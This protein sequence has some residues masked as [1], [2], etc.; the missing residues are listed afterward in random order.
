MNTSNIKKYAPKARNDFIAAIAKQAAKYGITDKSIEPVVEKGDLAVI[1]DSVFPSTVIKARTAL[2]K[3][4]EQLGFQQVVEQVAYSW[5]NRLC[6]IRYMELKGYLDHGRRVLS[7]A[8]GS[9][10]LPQILEDCLD[11]ELPGLNLEKVR[12][13]KL[14]GT[15]DEALYRELLLGQCHALHQAMPFLFESV[16][17][18]SELL[19][20][21]NLTKTDSLIRE[22]VEVIPEEDWQEV[23]VIGWLYQFY[24]S[25]KKDQVIGKV[26]KSEDIPAATQLFT[27]NWI[28]KYLVQNS[29]GRQ[30]LQTYPESPLKSQ[31]EYYIEPAEQTAEVQEQLKAITP[32]QIDPEAIKVLDPA[33]GSGH[34]LVEAYKVLKAI[35]EERGYRSR[36]IPQ[37]ILEKNL[38]GLDIDDRAAQLAGFALLMLAREDDRRIF[39]RELKLNVL[40]V[41]ESK[42]ID[43]DSN[44]RDAELP[45]DDTYK[46]AQ[47]VWH[48]FEQG[49]TFG[50]LIDIPASYESGLKALLDDLYG[51]ASQG[52]MLQKPAA[53][54]LLTIVNQALVLSQRYDAVVANP[55]YM[56]RSYY[57]K[58]LKK[59]VDNRFEIVKENIFSVFMER[60]FM[61]L[62]PAGVNAQINMH[63]WMFISRFEKYRD[64]LL[65]KHSLG[66]MLHLGP[67][68]FPEISGEVVQNTAFIYA[69]NFI[70]GYL[71][72]IYRLVD[73]DTDKKE[74]DFLEGR[75]K[76]TF[77][78]LNFLNI[79]GAPF[80]YW[81]SPSIYDAFNNF[82]TAGNHIET[83][84][85]L[86]TANNDLFLR[87]WYEVNDKSVANEHAN[88]EQKKWFPY[89]KGGG[90]RRWYGYLDL[91]VNWEN[92]GKDVRNNIDPITGRIRSHNYNGE[93][94][95]R[96]GFTWSGISSAGFSVRYVPQGYMF[97]AKGPMGFSSPENLLPFMA[98]FNC[99][100]S[101]FLMS[102]LAPTLDFKLGH[103]LKLPLQ[104][105][106]ED[107]VLAHNA[108]RCIDI[109]R[110]DWDSFE[111]SRGF[112]RPNILD[113]NPRVRE[114]VDNHL[115]KSRKIVDELADLERENNRILLE[116]YSLQHVINPDIN[117]NE[118]TLQCNLEYRYSGFKG[119]APKR[120]LFICDLIRELMSYSIGC[121]MGRY[122][123]DR[124]GLIYA[125]ESNTG[126]SGI[127]GEDT[128]KTFPADDDGI[129]P[130][131]DQ[132]WFSDDASNRFSDF[133][134][135][136]WQD[137]LRGRSKFCV[138][139]KTP[140]L[141]HHRSSAPSSRPSKKMAN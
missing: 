113:G 121:M 136:A 5:F 8:D 84:E 24:I 15:K 65:K 96:E 51:I 39:G 28:V 79:D 99:K 23:E 74:V 105:S 64:N 118:V 41:Q 117:I 137:D 27:P 2:A 31:M 20:P 126:F 47:D 63:A 119:D 72:T 97:D 52:G 111:I 61:L 87:S 78:C 125:Q 53:Q 80:V 40:A 103:V 88:K 129:I 68:A 66:S 107:G 56:G 83:R 82:H 101:T 33:C 128:Y 98:F 133:I 109:S 140:N 67:N 95:Y 38:Y 120:D 18:E 127:V 37:L 69:N 93:Y 16:D 70:D 132:E 60:A 135:V 86:A 36:D 71:S 22:L 10:G 7:S 45:E 138:K 114:S 48:R 115:I 13:L 54:E 102:M 59:F 100:I 6:A 77:D 26:V 94:A 134:G 108:K 25:E 34:I 89:N 1:G 85:G 123:L 43:L 29:V 106:N 58:D 112:S 3:K 35:Y 116:R 91:L 122:S 30:W 46:M 55:P 17:D 75:E 81:A 92:D 11:I 32:D 42:H 141:S 124:K 130:I 14:D 110:N 76:H 9:A 139:V 131:T 62:T 19:L 104:P 57:N 12:E 21:E 90:E 49:K 73:G 50:S 4:V 44:W